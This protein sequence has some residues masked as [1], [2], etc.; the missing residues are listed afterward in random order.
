MLDINKLLNVDSMAPCDA[1]AYLQDLDSWNEDQAR[2]MA[3]SE[4][5][6][7]TDLH[8]DVI[9]FMRD[10]YSDCGPAANARTLLKTLESA[11]AD[12]G[13]RKYLYQLFP[14]GPVTQ[15]CKLAGLPTPPGN[16]DPSF[17]SVH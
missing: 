1:D 2:E 17:G 13:G 15:G 8:L 11:Y 14:H 7:L 9:C 6:E 4:G 3:K 16:A 10:Q 12:Q 5:L